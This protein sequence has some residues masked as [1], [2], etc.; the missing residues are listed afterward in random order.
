MRLVLDTNVVV[1]G[2]L[3]HGAPR[4]LIDAAIDGESVTLYSSP[5]LIVELA[6]TLAYAKFAKRIAQFETSV[7]ALVAQYEAL[8]TLVSPTHTPRIVADDPDDDHVIACAVA[9]N[10]K[11]IVSG[12]KHLLTIKSYQN[13]S[14]LS[15]AEA[16]RTTEANR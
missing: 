6:N 15:P 3:W 16:L 12:D 11:A 2:L 7:V 10:A 8:V 14:I 1:A 9:A 4:R 5:V 13:I